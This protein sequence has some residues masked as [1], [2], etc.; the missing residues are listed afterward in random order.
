MFKEK[1]NSGNWARNTG[2]PGEGLEERVRQVMGQE[3]GNIKRW[4][5]WTEMG[6][7]KRYMDREKGDIQRYVRI[8][9]TLRDG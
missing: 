4:V 2:K 5:R 6:E 1:R 8:K 3:K 9:G 7:E